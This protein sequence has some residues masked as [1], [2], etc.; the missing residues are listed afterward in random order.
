MGFNF[1]RGKTV[2]TLL[3]FLAVAVTRAQDL[4]VSKE[5]ADSFRSFDV[6][7]LDPSHD[8]H[9]IRLRADGRD[10]DL[11]IAPHDLRS[12]SFRAM[13]RNAGGERDLDRSPSNTYKGQVVGEQNSDVRLTMD[14]SK[15]EGYFT[16]RGER[17]FIERADKYS[18][19]AASDD[20]VIY[21]GGDF[22]NAYAIGCGAPLEEKIERG[23]DLANR[24][25]TENSLGIKSIEIATDSDFEYVTALGGVA[26]A[27]SEI[28]SIL[29]MAEG[30]YNTQLNLAMSVVFQHTWSTPDPFLGATA[31]ATVRNF[32]GYWN[33]NFPVSTTP[34]DTAHLFSAKANVLA[35]G[36]AFI[37]VICRNPTFAYGMSGRV[38]WAPG[39]FLLTAHEIGHN[40]GANHVDATQGCTNSL[41]NVQL[42]ISTPFSFCTYSENEIATFINAN[43]SC[44]S[45]LSTCAFDF[46]GD[47]KADISVFRASGGVWFLNQSTAGFKGIQFGQN[48]DRPVSADYD[49]DGKSDIAVYRNGFWYWLDSSTSTFKAVAFGLPDDVPVPADFDGDGK[50]DVA[51]FR[52][53]NGYW[54]QIQSRAGTFTAISHGLRGDVPLPADFDGDGKA[55]VNVFRPSTGNWYRINS[56]TNTFYG[57]QF[58]TAGDKP[59]MGDFDGDAKADIAVWRPSNGGWY[60]LSSTGPVKATL[61]GV[62]TDIPTPADYDGD[63][64]TDIAVYRPSNGTWYRLNSSNDSFAAMQFGIGSDNPVPS[65]Y[66]R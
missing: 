25:A 2:F 66:V 20:F 65:Y 37:G 60:I 56:L 7:R 46:D 16:S 31:E 50:A 54:Y 51:V 9:S 34:R 36:W 59:V 42:T 55:D 10:I 24:N 3:F 8:L 18:R 58:G 63:G 26:Q 49:G 35:Q 64:K 62:T 44:L 27:N 53:S 11:Q 15:I 6:A 21:R 17:F 57:V 47:K 33:L 40:L 48:G 45:P 13:D 22:I 32:Q 4:R 43:G 14:G 1:P 28:L 29:N 30:V 23:I 61:F 19:S 52:P 38:D 41:M 39:K 5:L 12:A